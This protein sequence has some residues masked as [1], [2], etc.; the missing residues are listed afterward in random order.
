MDYF[1]RK[2]DRFLTD[3]FMSDSLRTTLALLLKEV[4]R[5][6]RHAAADAVLHAEEPGTKWPASHY[7]G[8]I[9]NSHLI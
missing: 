4:A 1:E 7:S 6:Q 5:D 8:I 9:M 3:R 2:A